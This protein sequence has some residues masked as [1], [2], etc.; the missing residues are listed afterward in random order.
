MKMTMSRIGFDVYHEKNQIIG[1]F[2]NMVVFW[3]K[4]SGVR[5]LRGPARAEIKHR[6]KRNNELYECGPAT[7]V[8]ADLKRSST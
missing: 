7:L 3:L 5:S 6:I 1:R 8:M 2:A 4:K